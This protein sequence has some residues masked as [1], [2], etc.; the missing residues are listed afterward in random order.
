MKCRLTVFGGGCRKSHA[1]GSLEDPKV[2]IPPTCICV[3]IRSRVE[4]THESCGWRN[5]SRSPV[6]P[7]RHP[8]DGTEINGRGA[9]N[10]GDRNVE[11]ASVEG[12]AWALKLNGNIFNSEGE[13]FGP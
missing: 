12:A 3:G 1:T 13:N 8:H 2:E 11:C 6:P 7:F 9:H 10:R 4:K 5:V